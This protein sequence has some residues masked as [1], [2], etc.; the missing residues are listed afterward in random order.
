MDGLR[1]KHL[2]YAWISSG[3][4]VSSYLQWGRTV[5]PNTYQNN[6][7]EYMKT[8]TAITVHFL[9]PCDP[10]TSHEAEP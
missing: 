7:R 9:V 2:V 4:K 10:A 3:Y 5:Y 1:E 8:Y 6:S